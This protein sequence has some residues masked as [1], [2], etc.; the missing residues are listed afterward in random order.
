[1]AK[2]DSGQDGMC[3]TIVGTD[4]HAVPRQRR[5]RERC[6]VMDEPDGAYAHARTH[7]RQ[8]AEELSDFGDVVT[9][10]VSHKAGGPVNAE[11]PH[12]PRAV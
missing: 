11:L 3:P 1:M 4:V 2:T 12:E 9:D 8:A 7:R 5:T 6:A 10:G